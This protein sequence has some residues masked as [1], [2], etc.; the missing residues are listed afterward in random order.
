MKIVIL[1]HRLGGNFGGTLQGY[2]LQHTLEQSGHDV[3]TTD[4]HT[5]SVKKR[6]MAT[7]KQPIK[8]VLHIFRPSVSNMPV[9]SERLIIVNTRRFVDENIRTVR[10]DVIKNG[11]PN[12]YNALVVGSDQV[13]RQK[14]VP[15]DKY[16][17]DFAEKLDITRIS[18]A[19]SFGCDDL[20]EYSPALLKTS[21]RLAKKFDAISVRENSGVGLVKDYW[22]MNAEQ[23]VDPTLLLAADHYAKLVQRDS[24][25]V[26]G[27]KGNLFVYMLDHSGGKREIIDKT[28]S[29]MGL[30]PFEIMPPTAKSRKEFFANPDKYQLP[31]VTQWLQSFMD[32]EFVVTDSFHG[33]AFSIIFNKPFI[34]VGNKERGLARFTS[35]LKVFGLEDRLVSDAAEVTEELL[36]S[37]ID[38][39]RVNGIKK[40]E[41]KRSM[42]YLNRHLK[43]S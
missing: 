43:Q 21:A 27:S 23:H 24:Y 3:V 13:W 28:E 41:Q 40:K 15:V 17:F 1:T 22:G 20:S 34:A 32:A 4:F 6:L 42:E 26:I 7:F 5:T 36:N 10:R 2:A 8:Y 39:G 33:C 38:W 31:P 16:L 11:V 19:A 29:T 9:N 12:E 14:Y 37:K 30:K 18:Y 25:N 35:L